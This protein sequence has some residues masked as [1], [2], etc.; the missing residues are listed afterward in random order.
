MTASYPRVTYAYAFLSRFAELFFDHSPNGNFD[1]LAGPILVV[2]DLVLI[3]IRAQPFPGPEVQ[4][5]YPPPSLAE[6]VAITF[7]LQPIFKSLQAVGPHCKYE[8]NP[9]YCTFANSWSTP[10]REHSTCLYLCTVL[11]LR[12]EFSLVHET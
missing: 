12:L 11:L 1:P 2:V 10:C 5:P 3:P 9:R 6:T 4:P 7:R 8:A